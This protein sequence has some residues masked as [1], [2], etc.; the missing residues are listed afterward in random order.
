MR[1]HKQILTRFC[2]P[3]QITGLPI[4]HQHARA[5]HMIN[6]I[7]LDFQIEDHVSAGTLGQ[8]LHFR[9]AVGRAQRFAWLEFIGA[10]ELLPVFAP[11]RVIG[12]CARAIERRNPVFPV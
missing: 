4:M 9:R 6:V 5:A 12:S 8:R 7:G 3:A 10:N 1:T 11:E 2:Q